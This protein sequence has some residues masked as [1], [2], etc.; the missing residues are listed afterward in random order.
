MGTQLINPYCTTEDFGETDFPYLLSLSTFRVSAGLS[1]KKTDH[2]H[3]TKV[4]IGHAGI[5]NV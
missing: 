4:R 3:V 1:L 5:N 2:L